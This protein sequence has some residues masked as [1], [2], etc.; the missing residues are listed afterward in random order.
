MI[1]QCSTPR[2]PRV[3]DRNPAYNGD[4]TPSEVWRVGFHGPF[5]FTELQAVLRTV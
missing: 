4:H 1:S 3:E 2:K 5:A